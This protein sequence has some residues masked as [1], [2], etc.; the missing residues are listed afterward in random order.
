MQVVHGGTFP[1]QSERQESR[2]PGP[3]LWLP[4]LF[5]RRRLETGEQ[6]MGCFRRRVQ[7]HAE[8]G[9]HDA[10]VPEGP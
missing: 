5:T 2:S 10:G 3:G 6:G 4:Q 9:R 1:Q 7:S 8:D